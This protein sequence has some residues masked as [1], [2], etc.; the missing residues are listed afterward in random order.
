MNMIGDALVQRGQLVEGLASSEE[1]RRIFAE[2]E[3]VSVSFV[4]EYT[5]A[6]PEEA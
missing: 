5:K 3:A 2:G 4:P 6:F 1:A